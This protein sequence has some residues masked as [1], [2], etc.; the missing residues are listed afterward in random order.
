MSTGVNW[1]EFK[2]S[3]P[4]RCNINFVNASVIRVYVARARPLWMM[5]MKFG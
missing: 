2:L 1:K 5:W 3:F 4:Y